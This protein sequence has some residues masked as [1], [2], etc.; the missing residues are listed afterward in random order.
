MDQWKAILATLMIFG[1][2]VGTG[3]LLTRQTAPETPTP[4]QNGTSRFQPQS[5]GKEARPV[6]FRSS[7][8]LD[9]HLEL[10]EEQKNQIRELTKQS[11]QR[12]FEFGEPF[13]EQLREEH[14]D[15]QKQIRGTLTPEQTRVFDNLP[16]F[17]FNK[18][19]G[20]PKGRPPHRS[21][22]TPHFQKK[23]APPNPDTPPSEAEQSGP[24]L[25]DLKNA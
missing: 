19:P 16:H 20:R 7:G 2:G 13:R 6:F 5:N 21:G 4:P 12:I 3:H 24:S 17:R 11:H 8:Y 1:S 25:P 22:P 15:L 18:E 10:S 23:P 9:R 14:R